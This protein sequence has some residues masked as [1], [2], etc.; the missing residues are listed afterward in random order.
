MDETLATHFTEW[1]R[2]KHQLLTHCNIVPAFLWFSEL[3]CSSARPG[4]PRLETF[5]HRLPGSLSLVLILGQWQQLAEASYLGGVCQEDGA[6]N[7]LMIILKK[8]KENPNLQN[9]VWNIF[10]LRTGWKTRIALGPAI[11]RLSSWLHHFE[12]YQI[13]W[14]YTTYLKSESNNT[15]AHLWKC[16][17][18]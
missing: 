5:L 15:G 8:R 16:L 17:V 13:W 18:D 11:S 1:K 7:T 10:I 14:R 12:W 9:N 4:A 6:S 3:G 2:G